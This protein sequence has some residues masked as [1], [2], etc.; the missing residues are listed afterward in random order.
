[1]KNIRAFF[2]SVLCGLVALAGAQGLRFSQPPSAKRFSDGALE[3]SASVSCADPSLLL[4]AR[5]VFS[6]RSGL[7]EPSGP[8]APSPPSLALSPAGC[9]G[10]RL[11]LRRAFFPGTPAVLRAEL[12][13]GGDSVTDVHSLLTGE[14]GSLLSLRRFCAR[15]RNGEPE[16]IEVR[17]VSALPVS[18]SKVR[19]E[20]R[21]L[22]GASALEPGESLLA[23]AA[24]DT[25]ELRLWQP[26]GRAFPLSSWP[27]LRNTGDTLRLSVDVAARNGAIASL[28]LDSVVYGA[29]ASSRE[30]CASLASEESGGAAHGFALEAPP[31]RWNRR[32]GPWTLSVT[33]PADGFYDLRVYDLD[34]LALC[35]LARG[36]SGPRTF[37]MSS[38]TCARLPAS[39]TT[40]LLWLQPRGAPAVRKLLRITP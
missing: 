13:D 16:W 2:A 32:A 34:G 19:L 12:T 7:G 20:A 1:M 14:A 18:L 9:E 33:A 11:P 17:N 23:V 39:A 8:D 4:G 10:D 35:A 28:I 25:A 37:G 22:S 30:A 3:W 36:A 21:A 26:G 15:P 31:G 6:L 29:A 38:A 24:A 27:G 40:A 5:V